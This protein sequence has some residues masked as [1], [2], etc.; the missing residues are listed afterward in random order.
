MLEALGC[1][2]ECEAVEVAIAAATSGDTV[3]SMAK[4]LGLSFKQSAWLMGLASSALSN[5]TTSATSTT[6]ANTTATATATDSADAPSALPPKVEMK[7][8]EIKILKKVPV[9]VKSTDFKDYMPASGINS[10]T[11]QRK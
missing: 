5:N 4:A 6:T 1:E 2:T 8:W 9:D 11:T 10:S 3:S 7:G